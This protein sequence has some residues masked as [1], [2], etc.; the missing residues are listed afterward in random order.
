MAGK[1]EKKGK[2]GKKRKERKLVGKCIAERDHDITERE[3][4][5]PS[6]LHRLA[7]PQDSQSGWKMLH[8]TVVPSSALHFHEYSQHRWQ[9]IRCSSYVR[10]SLELIIRRA[11]FR[12]GSDTEYIPSSIRHELNQLQNKTKTAAAAAA[13][14]AATT[15][16]DKLEEKMI[17]S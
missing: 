5:D 1:K 9:I 2:K 17:I 14:A 8:D 15:K 11:S 7:I 12:T 13:A 6:F 10:H 16:I 4:T 3:K